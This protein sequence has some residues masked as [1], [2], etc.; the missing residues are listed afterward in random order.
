MTNPI[1]NEYGTQYWTLSNKLHRT[2][3]PAVIYKNGD[4]EWFVNDKLH[5]ID[6]PAVVFLETGNAWFISGELCATPKEYQRAANLTDEDM[7]FILL[8][9]KFE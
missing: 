5:R 6:G 3:G 8:K 2:D 9:Y 4:K 7:S 1:I